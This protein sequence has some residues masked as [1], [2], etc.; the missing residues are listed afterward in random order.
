MKI[1]AMIPARLGSTR[2]PNKNIRL[3]NNK[4]LVQYVIDTAKQ[5]SCFDSVYVN[6]ESDILREIAENCSVDFYK[7]SEYMSS[8]KV[9]N[10]H[11]AQDFLQNVDC[12]ILIQVLPTSPFITTK[13]I[14]SFVDAM[15]EGDFDTMVSVT[16]QQIECMFKGKP[17]NF[18]QKK[19][20]PPSQEVTP[21]QPYACSLM[22]WKKEN[23]LENMEKHG[24]AYHGG[25]GKIGTFTLKGYSTIDIDNEEDFNLAEV[26]AKHLNSKP[27]APKYYTPGEVFDHDRL[28]VLL[29]DGVDNNN[30]DNFNKEVVSVEE[31]IKNNP[32]DRCWSHT[33]VNSKSTCS[34]L[35]AQMPG[36]GNRLHYH[37]DW[38]EWW[39]IM[40]GQ[41]EWFVEGETLTVKE[42]D[43]VFIE[44]NKKHK[45]TAAG[46]S[47][48]IRMAVSR[49]DVDHIYP[50]N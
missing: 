6:S 27:P 4:P 12:D 17:I 36:E 1:V 28:R 26:T 18:D 14:Q 37:S 9:T 42:G 2:V 49:E 29:E 24:C 13:E 40:K 30:M 16:D 8:D 50:G 47:Q 45:I 5:L 44:R 39:Y 22:G 15:I 41:W 34:T 32:T 10:D 20:T 25:D 21:V 48:A 31:I 3:L 19:V 35:I 7:R 33:L 11:F 46:N 43:V 38:D 23:Y